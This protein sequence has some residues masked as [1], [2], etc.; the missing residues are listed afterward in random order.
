MAS[1]NSQASDASIV[2]P[3]TIAI[4]ATPVDMKALARDPIRAGMLYA[5]MDG[6][7]L[8]AVE[9][10]SVP[11][12][13]AS[14][15]SGHLAS[16]SDCGLVRATKQGGRSYY[17]LAGAQVARMIESIVQANP[18]LAAM[19]PA[20]PTGPRD[21]AV[22]AARTCHGHLAGRLGVAIAD[23]LAA[24]GHVRLADA[25]GV[26]TQTGVALFGDAGIDVT[27]LGNGGKAAR[28]LCRPC[29]DWS[30]R[31]PHLGGAL[32]AALCAQGM[33]R[34]WIRRVD[35]TRAVAVMPE[36]RRVF[37]QAFGVRFPV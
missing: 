6:R 16:M 7:A 32:G 18:D 10:A 5:L 25:A 9:L 2:R 4:A 20:P 14:I 1:A 22:R 30:E 24:G 17:S 12:V 19:R 28:L 27:A 21:A 31:R 23:A 3:A 33:Q 29:L 11:G 15:A 36:G 34:Q 8:T 13:T 35:G 26:L 37:E